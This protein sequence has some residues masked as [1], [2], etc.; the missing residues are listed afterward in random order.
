MSNITE[1]LAYAAQH[2]PAFMSALGAAARGQAEG[3]L[4]ARTT[5]LIYLGTLA[6]LGAEESFRFHLKEALENGITEEEALHAAVCTFTAAG[7]T[8]LLKVLD[9]FLRKGE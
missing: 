5:R 8:P 2:Q 7:I 1:R 4:D 3:P 9:S 6:A